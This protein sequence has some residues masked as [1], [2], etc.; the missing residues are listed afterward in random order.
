M[1]SIGY[2]TRVSPG[3]AEV[4][5]GKHAQCADCGACIAAADERE[6][7][8][9]AANDLGA[10]E[11][12]KVEIEISPGRLVR[13]ALLM[14]LLPIFL[15][16]GGGFTGYYLGGPLGLPPTLVAIGLGCLAFA[17]SF[18]VLG[19]A[20]RADRKSG[21]PRIVRILDDGSEGGC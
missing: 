12:A 4:L 2:V 15:A 14:F 13:A 6:R 3:L 10:G 17:G 5:L 8:I 9:E 18:L 16:L 7:S 20:Q 11:G 1:R 21:L 19:S